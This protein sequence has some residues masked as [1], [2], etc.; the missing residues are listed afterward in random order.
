MSH[1]PNS[2]ASGPQRSRR[3]RV[4]CLLAVAVAAGAVGL[5]AWAVYEW[6]V[7]RGPAPDWSEN[8]LGAIGADHP[9]DRRHLIRP[10]LV[11]EADVDVLLG[12]V[13]R[14]DAAPAPAYVV[15]I[16]KLAPPP[17]GIG[18]R[19]A[20]AGMD[21]DFTVVSSVTWNPPAGEPLSVEY[22]Q[23]WEPFGERFRI[24][25]TEY[26]LESGRLFLV[27]PTVRPHAVVQVGADVR[28]AL[29]DQRWDRGQREGARKAV[30]ELRARH[31]AVRDFLGRPDGP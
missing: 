19:S 23:R 20:H 14:P 29:P 6:A 12:L 15:L 9:R 25:G 24:D 2:G 4:G 26:P 8:A 5:G 13:G 30:A 31:P 17:S 3:S 22:D 10:F 27:D 21:F 16:R 28:E 18:L 1:A 7:S 11:E